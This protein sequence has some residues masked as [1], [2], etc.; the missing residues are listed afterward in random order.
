MAIQLTLKD[1]FLEKRLH[2]LRGS[3]NLYERYTVVHKLL[4]DKVFPYITSL[5]NANSGVFLTD[6][7]I[8]HIR[9]VVIKASG[10]AEGLHSKLSAY[11]IFLLLVAIMVHDIGNALGR[12]GHE[13]KIDEVL[14]QVFGPL[15]FDQLDRAVAVQMAGVHGGTIGGSK[16]TI[17]SLDRQTSWKSQSIRPQLIAAILRLADELAENRD[18]A[19]SLGLSLDAI[20]PGSQIFHVFAYALHTFTAD[21]RASELQMLFAADSDHFLRQYGKGTGQVYLLDEIFERTIKAYF[22]ARYCSRYLAG[23]LM[24]DKVRVRVEIYQKGRRIEDV[25]YL[26]EEHDHPGLITADIYK[27]APELKNF[28]NGQPLSAANLQNILK[29]KLEALVQ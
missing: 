7:G 24:F 29:T 13:A 6:H 18:R 8:D 12:R 11:E 2:K 9:E 16:D 23:E 21:S 20:P 15:G 14:D 22:E 5:G 1:T 4:E 17:R 28:E 25:K 27:M 19:S 10:L 26:I 3:N